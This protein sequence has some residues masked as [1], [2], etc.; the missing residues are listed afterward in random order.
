MKLLLGHNK[1]TSGSA[2][3]F[4][5][6]IKTESISIRAR[7]G[8]L[9]Q[10]I[11]FYEYMTAREIL[12]FTMRFYYGGPKNLIKQRVNEILK[13]VV[14]DEKA[15]RPVKGFSGGERQR[16]GLGQA[17]VNHPELLILDEPAASLDPLGRRD[18]LKVMN[19]LRKDSTI[20]Y[21]THILDDV[22]KV[23]DTVAILNKG[24]L[25][26]QGPIEEILKGGEG[27][28]Y[29]VKLKGADVDDLRSR[30]SAQSWI[31]NVIVEQDASV[32]E[33]QIS[34]TDDGAAEDNLLGLIQAKGNKVLDYGEKEVQLEDIFIKLIKE[35]GDKNGN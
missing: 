5:Q 32:S 14:L 25:I 30:L 2:T 31:S 28:I 19:H 12:N 17:E 24:K 11:R 27:T 6:D 16:L 13:M 35:G 29:A 26:T 10:E 1:P 18:L 33:W 21:S 4:G 20:F 22:Q 3:I 34:V 23:S 15:D 9:P 8:F 7:I